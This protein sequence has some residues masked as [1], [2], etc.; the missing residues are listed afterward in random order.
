MNILVLNYEFPPL[1][2]WAANATYYMLQEFSKNKELKI[3]LVTSSTWEYREEQFSDNIK[4]YYLDIWKNPEKLHFQSQIDL[5]KYSWK[6]YKF[7]DKLF[8]T[9]W[10]DLIHAFFGVPCGYLAMRFKQ[11]YNIPYIVSLRWWDVP[12]HSPRFAFI[13]KFLKPIIIKVWEN[14]NWVITNSE[15]LK[16]EALLSN[17]NQDILVIYNWISLEKFNQ[18]KKLND[19]FN[20][21]YVWRLNI[22][23]WIEY[24]VDWFVEFNKKFSNVKLTIIWDGPLKKKLLEKWKESNVEFLGKLNHDELI[25]FYF[26]SDIYILPSLNEWMSNTLLEAMAAKLPVI[27]TDTWGTKEL[28]NDNGWIVEKQNQKDIKEKL[29]LA[30]EIWKKWDLKQLGEKSFEKVKDMTWWSMANQYFEIY[31]KIICVE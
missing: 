12:W 11:K 23:K 31:N 9:Q 2:W 15:W 14:S 16:Q 10:F 18:D 28:F 6:S 1:W 19:I 24:L 4:I 17:P 7:V 27:I 21:L 13:Y 8:Q 25:E 5:L 29:Q 26:Q 3:T 22:V 20:V 30:Y